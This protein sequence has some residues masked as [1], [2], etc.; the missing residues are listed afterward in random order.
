MVIYSPKNHEKEIY[1]IFHKLGD[2]SSTERY[3][4]VLVGFNYI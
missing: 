1:E 3:K 2:I 4:I